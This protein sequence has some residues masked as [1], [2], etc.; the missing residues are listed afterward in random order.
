MIR[1]NSTLLRTLVLGLILGT[2]LRGSA[3]TEPTGAFSSEQRDELSATIQSLSDLEG[4]EIDET[5]KLIPVPT[6]PIPLEEA[7]VAHELGENTD[8]E[9]ERGDG[10]P[11]TEKPRKDGVD[12]AKRI[13]GYD[14]RYP[15][16]NTTTYPF[17]TIGLVQT[18]SGTCTGTMV[19]P[20]HMVTASHC[21]QWNGNGTIGWL[22]FTPGSAPGGY[23]PWGSAWSTRVRYF[24]RVSGSLD[25]WRIA[26]DYVVVVLDRE[27][28]R[29]TGWMGWRT[30]W[31]GWNGGSYWLTA[32]YPGDRAG[33]M[34]GQHGCSITGTHSFSGGAAMALYSYCDTYFGQSGSS[35]YSYFNGMPAMV[36]VV[37]AENPSTNF[38]AGG[39][40]LSYLIS[41]MRNDYP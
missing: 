9:G 29:S 17:S 22:K 40:R 2:P 21:L 14:N 41:S 36:G 31:T 25:M 33:R 10:S 13:F 11:A 5:R 12:G 19:G 37:S 16:W 7:I 27:I 26:N 18:A 20:R 15:I 23:A 28:G 38:F 1:S 35:I 8:Q 32:G 30:Y 39:S 6:D 34:V 24:E 4:K 3:A